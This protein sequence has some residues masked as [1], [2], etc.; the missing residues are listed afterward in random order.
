M[1]FPR[2]GRISAAQILAELGD[3][4]ARFDS[5]EHLEA[6]AGGVDGRLIP[7]TQQPA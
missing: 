3:E 6:E 2:S 5:H 7:L 1:S 4:R